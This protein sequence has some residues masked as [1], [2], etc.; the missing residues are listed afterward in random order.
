MV[1]GLCTSGEVGQGTILMGA[2]LLYA[3]WLALA[4]GDI[5]A[6][7]EHIGNS[8]YIIICMV[9]TRD[10]FE[11]RV[12]ILN[13]QSQEFSESGYAQSLVALGSCVPEVETIGYIQQALAA[14]SSWQLLLQNYG[15]DGWFDSIGQIS[16]HRESS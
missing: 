14:V 13:L 3:H 6:S 12:V 15:L 7:P 4:L 8:T 9:D 1:K 11:F 10:V 5:N 2:T 16:I